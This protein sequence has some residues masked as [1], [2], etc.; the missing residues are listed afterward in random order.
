MGGG[1]DEAPPLPK[2]GARPLAPP[3]GQREGAFAKWVRLL[4]SQENERNS[5]AA[6]I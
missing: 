2:P 1:R 6:K 3:G 4:P 5:N